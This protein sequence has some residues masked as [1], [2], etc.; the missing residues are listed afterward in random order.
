MMLP[1]SRRMSSTGSDGGVEG[2]DA[3]L[4]PPRGLNIS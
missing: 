2:E 4:C 1:P 3:L